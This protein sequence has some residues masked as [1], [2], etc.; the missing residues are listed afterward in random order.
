MEFGG[1]AAFLQP[2]REIEFTIRKKNLLR[3]F[4]GGWVKCMRMSPPPRA[5][6]GCKDLRVHGGAW[7]C[8]RLQRD[9][10]GMEGMEN[11]LEIRWKWMRNVWKP[12]K[13]HVISLKWME[14]R[15]KMQENQWKCMK[16]DSKRLKMK[17][18]HWNGMKQ[19]C[20]ISNPTFENGTNKMNESMM[21]K[22]MN[23]WMI[24]EWTNDESQLQLL[25]V[26]R[27]KWMNP[28]WMN[29]WIIE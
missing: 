16:N 13:K 3:S 22:S 11:Q 25:R 29:Q 1:I 14:N 2:K 15:L 21:N 19:W 4:L 5:G 18:F 28:W 10:A 24:N 7:G 9:G 26:D 8:M 20:Q 23:K 6:A 17:D 27:T 12:M